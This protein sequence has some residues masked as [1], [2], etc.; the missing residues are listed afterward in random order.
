[1]ATQ[2]RTPPRRPAP[3]RAA[4]WPGT[5]AAFLGD[6]GWS[7]EADADQT[8]FLTGFACA[9]GTIEITVRWAPDDEILSVCAELPIALVDEGDEAPDDPAWTV[10]AGPAVD[11]I[12]DFAIALSAGLP[13][14]AFE[15]NLDLGVVQFR[16]GVLALGCA[17]S[18]ELVRNH[19]WAAAQVAERYL[20][21]FQRVARRE[22]GVAAAIRACYDGEPEGD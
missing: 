6:D 14:G 13:A 19:V 8:E 7:F 15:S 17:P 18:R 20:P 3:P 5:I 10:A 16:I 4:G 21:L 11:E 2:S 22:I 12:T 1:M 9:A